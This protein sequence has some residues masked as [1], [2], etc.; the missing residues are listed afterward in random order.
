MINLTLK[1]VNASEVSGSQLVLDFLLWISLL[2]VGLL[3]IETAMRFFFSYTTS[4]LGHR[5]GNTLTKRPLVP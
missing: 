2:Q 1:K 4:W 5:V 3:V